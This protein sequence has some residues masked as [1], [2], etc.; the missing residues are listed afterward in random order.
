MDIG[1]KVMNLH[2]G[3]AIAINVLAFTWGNAI[4]ADD[5]EQAQ[6]IV[7]KA[8]ALAEEKKLDQAIELM[9]KAIALDPTNDLYLAMASDYEYKAEKFADGL[10]HAARAIQLNDQVGAYY[11]L[12]AA[13]AL[14]AQDLERAREYCRTVLKGGPAKFGAQ[15][16]RDIEILKALVVDRTYTLHWNLDP[17]RGRGT[18]G[19]WII[20][21][22]KGDLPSQTT[23]YEVE[24]V[25]SH[26]LVKGPVNDV[27]HII[28]RG[29]EPFKLRTIVTVKP[30]SMKKALEKQPTDPV[31]AEA[32]AYLAPTELINP[33]SPALAKVAAELKGKTPIETARNILHWMK[34]NVDY[35]LDKANVVDLDF[36]SIEEVLQ[37][38]SAECRGYSLL[39]TALCRAADV[40]ARP[41]WG[42]IR[43]SA[44]QDQRFGD[45][46]SHNWAE[47]YLAGAGWVPVDPQKPETLGALPTSCIRIAIDS[48]KSKDNPETWPMLNLIYMNDGT[49]KFEEKLADLT[50]K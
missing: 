10:E 40:P 14:G 46:A 4:L 13:N 6:Q 35:K 37:R 34:T 19:T 28:P 50:E 25:R 1:D 22:P 48:V 16:C 3:I 27:L 8:Q 41:V 31:P 29:D 32:R 36:K 23:R 15:S 45:I 38:R 39:F 11:V 5:T 43:V 30:I 17:K 26:R 2:R 33:R 9:K 42:L 47:V 24:G 7:E 21:V 44:G 18:Q 49:L 20:S 12:G